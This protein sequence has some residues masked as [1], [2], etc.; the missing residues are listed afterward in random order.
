MTE[1]RSHPHLTLAEHLAQ[2][3]AAAHAIWRRHS[4]TLR[5]VTA[6]A[7]QW[8]E[9]GVNWHDAGKASPAF[10]QYIADPLKYRGSRKSKAHTPLSTVCALHHAQVEG[11]DWRRALATA[12]LAAGHHSEFKTLADLDNAYCSMQDVIDDQIR[13]LDWAALNRAIGVNL[14]PPA[15]GMSGEDLCV[16][17]S[18]YLDEL[19]EQLHCLELADAVLF[20]L[21]CQ[22][23][24]SVLLEADKAFLA[25]AEKDRMMYVTPRQAALQPTLVD[26]FLADKPPAAINPLRTEA[27]QEMY[28]GLAACGDHRIQTMTLPTG[29]GKTLLAASWTLTLRERITREEGQPP[30]VL[31]VLPYLAVIEQTASEYEKVFADHVQPGELISYHSLSDRT[32]AP[33][34]EDTSQ[35]FFL[36]TWQSDIVVTTFDQ[37]LFAL[38]SPKARHQ[39]RF[40]NLADSL[41]VLD[42]VQAFPCV[43]WEPLRLALDALTKLGTTRVLAMSATQPGFLA[44]PHE[45]AAPYELIASCEDFFRQMRR[46]RIVLRHQIP[47]KLS[48]FIEECRGRLSQWQ[49]QRVM[50]TLNTRRSARR[51]RDELAKNLPPGMM[52]EFLS[53]DVTPKDR[54]AAIERIKE[55]AK[56]NQPCLVVST[57]C[58]EAGVDLDMDFIIRDFGPLDSLIQIA[59]RCNRHGM[60]KRG[61]IEIV[62]LQE[63]ENDRTFESYIYDKIQIQATRQILGDK[64]A[65]CEEDVFPLTRAYFEQLA[66]GK[67]TGA[68]EL[69]RWSRWE[70]MTERVRNLLRGPERPQTSFLVVENDSR[71]PNDLDVALNEDDWARRR[72]LRKLAPRIAQ[73]TV[74]VFTSNQLTP[75][76]YGDPFPPKAAKD[77]EW[78]WLLRPGYYCPERGLDLGVRSDDGELW[79]LI[80]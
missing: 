64:E 79:G 6:D 36:D 72:A 61:I 69:K 20:R 22:L 51:V 38:L 77:E 52:L 12:L 21:L 42:E 58:V 40:H 55:F 41:I 43:L 14:L 18:D 31:I 13:L 4:R 56:T 39:M 65:I 78:F 45:L 30:L 57:Q 34:L 17:A 50:L 1:L 73:N 48:M 47:M 25:L 16:K 63:D 2:I 68:E 75:N 76:L 70:E 35:D 67:D 15:D 62:L 80:L 3:R 71:L 9:D 37:F 10:Q 7:V 46:Y 74:R 23:A 8:F 26:R 29:V 5:R 33:D 27:R 59:G 28:A 24:F 66:D 49:G 54:L 32:Y 44:A 11:W 53:A 60:R 19:G